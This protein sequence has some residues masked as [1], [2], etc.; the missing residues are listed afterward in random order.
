MERLSLL[1]LFVALLAYPASGQEPAHTIE[2]LGRILQVGDEIQVVDSSGTRIQGRFEGIEASSLL[3]NKKRVLPG[4]SIQ[5]VRK[6]HHDLWWNGVL[7][8][9]GI[10]A[11]TGWS[12]VRSHCGSDDSECTAVGTAAITLPGIGI[13]AATGAL[14]DFSIKKFDTVFAAQERSGKRSLMIA[15]MFIGREKGIRLSLSF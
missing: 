13:G 2:D 7:I 9:G 5:E 4:I 8:G 11:L 12:I 15:P 14:I 6:R 10:G 3:L 1:L